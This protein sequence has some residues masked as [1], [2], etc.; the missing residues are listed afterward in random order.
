[1]T[2]PTADV[3]KRQVLWHTF[4]ARQPSASWRSICA[5]IGQADR[6]CAD[7]LA[8]IGL[9][10]SDVLPELAEALE[11]LECNEETYLVLDSFELSGLPTP[12]T[13]LDV[14]KRQGQHRGDHAGNRKSF[15]HPLTA[16]PSGIECSL[17]S[18]LFS[19]EWSKSCAGMG[20]A[21]GLFWQG[22][23]NQWRR[24]GG[25]SPPPVMS[26]NR[27][28]WEWEIKPEGSRRGTEP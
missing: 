15:L 10:D 6:K 20:S 21:R 5:L 19:Q 12:E 16:F 2:A 24:G 7:E 27:Y 22:G 25:N 18:L 26:G 11:N 13:L 9:P 17:C 23:R 8:A 4:L 1:M 3:Y 14:Y 28:R